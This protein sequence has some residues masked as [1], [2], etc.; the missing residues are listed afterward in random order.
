M[1]RILF[2]LTCFLS[3]A[4][5]V[6]HAQPTPASAKTESVEQ[7]DREFLAS[8]QKAEAAQNPHAPAVTS[9]T[10]TSAEV[11][12]NVVPPVEK[13]RTASKRAAAQQ[14]VVAATKKSPASKKPVARAQT[15]KMRDVARPI[16]IV[17]VTTTTVT[18]K[19]KRGD[20]DDDE[21]DDD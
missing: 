9:S 6:L 18:T 8:M 17:K 4:A 1:F 12:S 20:R 15:A 10:V 2:S 3:A 21:D 7:V 11:A 19:T 5:P 16:R 13:P 14:K